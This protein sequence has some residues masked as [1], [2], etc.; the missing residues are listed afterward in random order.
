MIHEK[1]DNDVD[2]LFRTVFNYLDKEIRNFSARVITKK[3][4]SN[5][6]NVSSLVLSGIMHIRIGDL[7]PKAVIM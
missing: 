4:I 3:T 1:E 5:T 7:K 2:I 6:V